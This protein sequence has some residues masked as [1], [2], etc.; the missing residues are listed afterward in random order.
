MISFSKYGSD[1]ITL[2]N[3]LMPQQNRK[4]QLIEA[5]SLAPHPEGGYYRETYRS[6]I[7]VPIHEQNE[8]FEGPRSL[9]TGIY[10]ML[11]AGDFSAF[12]RIKS[13]EMW[14]FYDGCPILIHMIHPDGLYQEITLGRDVTAGQLPQF[15]VPAR[16]W[17]AAEPELPS[18]QKYD[19]LFALA[20]CTVA[21]G[22]DFDD[23]ELADTYMLKNAFPEHAEVI[24][25]FRR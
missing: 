11:G 13:D 20:G 5:L 3:H 2:K 12:H 19:G 22:F 7:N 14:H 15:V 21:P 8:A 6:A 4:N 10:Y 18:G 1:A 23:F 16:S 9:S 24:E 17:F 25:R